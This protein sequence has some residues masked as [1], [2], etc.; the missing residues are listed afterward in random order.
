[1]S[2]KTSEKTVDI[3]GVQ[4]YVLPIDVSSYT[5]PLYTGEK[6]FVDTLGQV[7]RFQEKQK[8]AEAFK[9]SLIQKSGKTEIRR[10]EKAKSLKDLLLEV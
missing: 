4:H 2:T 8:K 5:H 3:D 1:M 6:R 7:G 10:Q 9:K